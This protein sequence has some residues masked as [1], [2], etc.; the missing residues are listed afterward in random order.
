M[1]SLIQTLLEEVKFNQ[2]EIDLVVK[3]V[4][5]LKVKKGDFFI[6]PE[7]D[8]TVIC[9]ISKGITRNYF[10]VDNKETTYHFGVEGQFNSTI[11]AFDQ[12]MKGIEYIQALTD[13]ELYYINYTFVENLYKISHNFAKMGISI[14]QMNFV[15]LHKRTRDLL[16]ITALERYKK[17]AKE[18]SI[19]LQNV[20]Q[21]YLAS[22]LGMTPE[23]LSRIRKQISKNTQVSEH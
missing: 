18:N 14:M 15:A 11:A 22:Y 21:Y 5:F 16:T 8:E 3:E 13:C 20:N 23:S 17:L 4:K 6:T 19:L 10:M 12:S 7:L 9:Y 1:Q 2:K